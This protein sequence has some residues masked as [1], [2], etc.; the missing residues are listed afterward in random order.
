M[1]ESWPHYNSP[2]LT[3]ISI[4]LSHPLPVFS[5]EGFEFHQTLIP[6]S[7]SSRSGSPLRKHQKS[8]KSVS[9]KAQMELAPPSNTFQFNPEDIVHPRSADWAPAQEVAEYLHGKL[10]RSFDKEVRN[11]LRAECPR[12]ELP[13]KVVETP[14]IDASMLTFLN[15]FA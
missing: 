3:I 8:R 6:V 2:R 12:L 15:K 4:V 10:R 11:R 14:E 1:M 9:S 13:D 7:Q 5:L